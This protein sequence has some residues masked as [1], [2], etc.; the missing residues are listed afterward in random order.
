MKTPQIMIFLVTL[1]ACTDRQ[2]DR[3]VSEQP[4]K[5][6]ELKSSQD[7]ITKESISKNWQDGFGLTHNPDIDSIW[8]KPVSYYL[9]DKNCS[10]L[11]RDFYYGDLRPGDNEMT[12]ELLQLVTTDNKKLRPFYRWCL[13]KTILIQDGALAEYTGVPARKYAEKF[14]QE[15]FEYMDIDTSKE[16]YNEWVSSIQYSGFYETDDYKKPQEIKNRTIEAMKA[17]CDNC[18]DEINK[19]IDKFANE[20]FD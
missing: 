20:C 2:S 12:D 16:K 15:F 7:S 19:R 3:N 17:N 18:S 11:A 9:N 8:Y 1:S 14:P 10:R 6:T 4:I 5:T 13:N